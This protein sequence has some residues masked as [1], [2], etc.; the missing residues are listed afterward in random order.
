MTTI[1]AITLAAVLASATADRHAPASVVA[2]N[3]VEPTPATPKPPTAQAP[4]YK[5]VQARI[6]LTDGSVLNGAVL[7]PAIPFNTAMGRV[8][9][10]TPTLKEIAFNDTKPANTNVFKRARFALKDGSQVNGGIVAAE[11]P[12]RTVMG[13]VNIPTPKIVK[14]E[15]QQPAQPRGLPPSTVS[16]VGLVFSENFAGANARKFNGEIIAGPKGTDKALRV[17]LNDVAIGRIPLENFPNAEGTIEFWARIHGASERIPGSV[18]KANPSLFGFE[19]QNPDGASHKYNMR[20][21]ADDGHGN[22]GLL[23]T[24]LYLGGNR[25]ISFGSGGDSRR[26]LRGGEG[27]DGYNKISILILLK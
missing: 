10:S 21:D 6:T 15:F 17:K 18:V 11:I 13:R 5:P 12:V 1:L 25:L 8:R 22:N 19:L 2:H 16:R 9:V 4:A 14:I 3:V 27:M 23:G 24:E 26:L 7:S 20:F